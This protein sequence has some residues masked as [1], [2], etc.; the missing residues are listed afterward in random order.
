MQVTI[1]LPPILQSELSKQA[2]TLNL[3]IESLILQAIHQYTATQPPDPNYDPITP[4]IGTLD[5]GT[6]DLGENHD[7]YLGQA[8]LKELR[9]TE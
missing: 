4:L 8:L 7:Y 2:T 1:D 6:T 5:L 3:S 9:S